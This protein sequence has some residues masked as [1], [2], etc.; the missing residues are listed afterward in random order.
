MDYTRLKILSIFLVVNL[1]INM[2]CSTQA[3]RNGK[4]QEEGVSYSYLVKGCDEPSVINSFWDKEFWDSVL[5]ARLDHFMGEKP[6]HFPVTHVKLRYDS[7]YLY[8]IFH[9]KDQYVK[10]VAKKRNGKVW[11][12]SCVE[13]FFSP[14]TDV[15]RGYFNF[16]A[17]CKGV[18]LF[19]YHTGEGNH[20]GFVK[21]K[22]TI[23]IS[24][25][26]NGIK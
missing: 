16:E 2:P 17:N 4:V 20:S 3:I 14:G 25:I 6:E 5:P 21:K 24:N 7:N 15:A 18:Y 13:L 22:G 12:D 19:Q 9:V 1:L 10:A 23:Y 26:R 11:Q 8:V